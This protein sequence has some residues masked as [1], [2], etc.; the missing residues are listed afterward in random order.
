MPLYCFWF[1]VFVV[2][3]VFVLRLFVFCFCLFVCFLCLFMLVGL[4]MSY[5][6]LCVNVCSRVLPC[7]C[8]FVVLCYDLSV[9]CVCL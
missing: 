6:S 2:M 3:F 1:G 8:L 7:V 5:F 9:V 4:V